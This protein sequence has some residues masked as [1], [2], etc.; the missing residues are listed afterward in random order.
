[1]DGNLL[2]VAEYADLG[3]TETGYTELIDGRVLLSPNPSPDHNHASLNLA[4]Q[5]HDQLPE[6][7]EV[8]LSLDVDLGLA[9]PDEP[10]FSRRP[11]VLV[12]ERG[13]RQRVREQGGMLR[14]EEVLIAVEVVSPSS[15][16]TDNVHKR[17]DYADAGIP[18]YWI[19]DIDEPISAVLLRLTEEF[20]YTESQ[21]A[22]ETVE[23]TEPFGA[24]IDLKRLR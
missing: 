16:R 2:T 8:L 1:M 19:I 23:I 9:P 4:F 14:A 3:E 12:V 10:G 5:L 21:T 7:H 20:G 18:Y 11:D 17:D 15:R 22:T 6:R 13:A 24:T